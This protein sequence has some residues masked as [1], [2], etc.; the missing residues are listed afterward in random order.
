M[1]VPYKTWI[2][3]ADG[4]KYL[5][6]MNRGD[7]EY[8]VFKVLDHKEIDNPPT[9]EQGTDAPGRYEGSG[10]GRSAVEQTDWHRLGKERFAESLADKLNNWA[11]AD[12]YDRLILCADPRSL[13]QIRESLYDGVKSRLLGEIAR[14]LTDHPVDQIE[15]AVLKASE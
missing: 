6:L 3:V 15:Q 14:D 10:A 4:E 8:P 2:V 13:G 12:R 7:S 1:D 11:R 9:H 5:V